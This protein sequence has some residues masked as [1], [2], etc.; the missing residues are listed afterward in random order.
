MKSKVFEINMAGAL[1]L[2]VG[3]LIGFLK[4]GSLTSLVV[5][6]TFAALISTISYHAKAKRAILGKLRLS[7]VTG[8]RLLLGKSSEWW[9]FIFLTYVQWYGSA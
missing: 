4:S 1:L 2:V 7:N 8:V 6:F 9:L 5:S 3:G